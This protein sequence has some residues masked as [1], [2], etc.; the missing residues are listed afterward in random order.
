MKK[1]INGKAYDTDTARELGVWH[2]TWDTRDWNY[3]CETLYIKRTGEHFLHGE[4]GPMT[5]YARSDG[6]NRWRGGEDII[7]LTYD[8]ARKWAEEHLTADEYAAAF[9]VPDE[10]AEDVVLSV[11]I[12]ATLA[13]NIRAAAS[14]A[15]LSLSA[16]VTG[17]LTG[18][19]AK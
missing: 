10:S 17:I 18:A 9:G 11:H 2:N 5:R 12:P 14:K 1:I 8:S 7:P 19:E 6:D 13:A 15:G 4:G 3:T 16:Y